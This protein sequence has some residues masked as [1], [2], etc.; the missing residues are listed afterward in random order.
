MAAAQKAS[1]PIPIGVTTPMPVIAT[2]LSAGVIRA[3]PD[4]DTTMDELMPPNPQA[5]AMATSTFASRASFG[6]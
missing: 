1:L 3:L 2:R 6:T 4:R 5:F